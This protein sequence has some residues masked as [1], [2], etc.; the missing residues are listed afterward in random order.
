MLGVPLK[1]SLYWG[2]FH[3]KKGIRRNSPKVIQFYFHDS[4]LKCFTFQRARSFSLN[5]LQS[6][7]ERFGISLCPCDIAAPGWEVG[8]P[9]AGQRLSFFCP[10]RPFLISLSFRRGVEGPMCSS[11]VLM[12]HWCFFSTQTFA[13]SQSEGDKGDAPGAFSH[14]GLSYR[15]CLGSVLLGARS[16]GA[17]CTLGKSCSRRN[18][19]RKSSKPQNQGLYLY[20]RDVGLALN[21]SWQCFAA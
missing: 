16:A 19:A 10:T 14:W 5:G 17:C 2:N 20:V 13:I 21:W 11:S 12:D 4:L 15:C 18:A 1:G 8:N 7:I 3:F 6:L 9:V